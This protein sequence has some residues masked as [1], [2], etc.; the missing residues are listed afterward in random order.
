MPRHSET[1]HL[2]YSADQMFDLVADIGRYAEFLPWVQAMRIRSVE[3]DVVT[4]DMVVG[5]KMV[6]ERF[7]SRVTL[8]RPTKVHVDYISGPL[9]YLK[10]DWGFR[11]APDGG[12]EIDFTVDFEFRNKMFERLAGMFFHEAFR[13]MVASFE[14]RA[15]QVY[16]A[17]VTAPSGISSSS[18]T[19]AA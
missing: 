13:R 1:R 2:P 4:A 9:K 18:A 19:S 16:G 12:C 14:A 5:F 17:A 8:T 3:G 6:R 10:N 7:T 15:A 11:A